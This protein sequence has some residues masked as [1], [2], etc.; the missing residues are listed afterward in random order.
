MKIRWLKDGGV[1]SPCGYRAAGIAAG[2]KKTGKKDMAMVVSDKDA[3]VAA[4]FTTNQIKAAPVK[5]SMQYVRNGKVRGVVMNSGCANACTGLRGLTD[6]KSM[7]DLACR[8]QKFKKRQMLVCSTGRIGTFLPMKKIEPGIERL[9]SQLKRDGGAEAAEAIMTTDLVSKQCAVS[10]QADGKRV[11]IGG[12]VKGAG[13]IHPNMATM[14]CCIT[15]DAVIEKKTLQRCVLD[16]VE[17]SFNR[18]SVD[19]DMSTNDTVLVFANGA[20]G[21]HSIESYH[22]KFETFRAALGMVMKKLARLIIED[23]E[24]ISR[25]VELVVRGAARTED[26]KV[27][28]E[29][30]ARSPLVKTSWA[31]GEPNWGRIMDAMGYSRAKVREELVE[32]YYDG[33]IAVRGGVASSTPLTELRKVT[34]KRNFTITVNL[35]L[36]K[37]EYGLL[38]NDFTE[39]YVK[40]NKV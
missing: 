19:G 35:Q 16:A 8:L 5:V 33:L 40:I 24:G 27:V 32:I 29:F 13:M 18:I 6:A 9:V 31:G 11:T 23:G 15:T 4:T 25:V 14:L 2:V 39:E 21:N 17:A 30:I 12:M 1:T 36:G 22:P 34:R 26:A 28:A 38:T 37:G 20:A 7:A 10:F 3:V